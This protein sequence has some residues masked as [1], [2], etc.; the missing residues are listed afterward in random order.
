MVKDGKVKRMENGMMMDYTQFKEAL[1][2][3]LQEHFLGRG[4]VYYDNVVKTNDT[5]K[6]AVVVWQFGTAVR[7]TIYPEDIY[8]GYQQTGDFEKCAEEVIR[9][10]DMPLFINEGHIP[11]TWETA[12]RRLC[13][14][15]INRNWNREALKR[16]PHREYLDLAV[17]FY[18]FI[19][20]EGGMAATLPV[21]REC[22]EFWGVDAKDLWEAAQNNLREEDFRIEMMETVLEDVL[23]ENGD[24]E[25]ARQFRE[26]AQEA[27]EMGL[28]VVFNRNRSYGARAIL[29]KDLLREFAR[30]RGGSF[31]ILPCSRDVGKPVSGKTALLLAILGVSVLLLVHLIS[32][33]SILCRGICLVRTALRGASVRKLRAVAHVTASV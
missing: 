4:R 13:M 14:R 28:Y 6:E 33:G 15:V 21:S 26:E 17:V 9:A 12:K 20:E 27:E 1:K 10:C 16:L 25:A 31:Y 24:A 32:N 23:M 11:K 22:M 3:A 2:D 30:E 29:R 19:K 18:V 5:S 8:E 7:T